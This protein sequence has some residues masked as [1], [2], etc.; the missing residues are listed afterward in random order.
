VDSNSS[1]AAA[2]EY[3]GLDGASLA[4]GMYNDLGDDAPA[5]GSHH[6]GDYCRG[7]VEFHDFYLFTIS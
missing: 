5:I 6:S 1:T 7:A 3:Q 4:A 2:F